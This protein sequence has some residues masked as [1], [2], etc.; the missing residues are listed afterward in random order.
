MKITEFLIISKSEKIKLGH[1][2]LDLFA[3]MFVCLFV[4]IYL[5]TL[6]K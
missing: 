4:Y 1:E 3:C 6:S 2:N 5:F